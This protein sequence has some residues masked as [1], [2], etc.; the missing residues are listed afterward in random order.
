MKEV[1]FVQNNNFSFAALQ[2]KKH[3]Q[4][5]QKFVRLKSKEYFTPRTE[6][7][8]KNKKKISQK[9]MNFYNQKKD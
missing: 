1:Q 4:K 8:V 6:L 2:L 3:I 7:R 5:A 9:Y